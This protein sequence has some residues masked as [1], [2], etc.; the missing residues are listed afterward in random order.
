M[1]SEQYTEKRLYVLFRGVATLIGLF[2]CKKVKL[3]SKAH[4]WYRVVSRIEG[5][6]RGFHCFEGERLYLLIYSIALRNFCY[7]QGP[8]YEM[9]KWIQHSCKY[10]FKKQS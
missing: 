4:G 3:G 5:V 2:I 1:L 10:A 6:Q 8:P 9:K 7:P